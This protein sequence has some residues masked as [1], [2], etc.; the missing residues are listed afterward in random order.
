M[1]RIIMIETLACDRET[2]IGG[3]EYEVDEL[4][5]SQ[6]IRGDVAELAE[7]RIEPVEVT[8]EPAPKRK[9]TK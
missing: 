6:L 5:A 7:H 9:K 2:F 3:F 4:T 8:S 1:K